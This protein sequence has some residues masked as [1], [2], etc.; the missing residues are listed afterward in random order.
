M[1]TKGA[2]PRYSSPGRRC[3]VGGRLRAWRGCHLGAK[4][5]FPVIGVA[6][7]AYRYRRAARAHL[8]A[9]TGLAVVKIR[10]NSNKLK[11]TYVTGLHGVQQGPPGADAATG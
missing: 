6:D 1:E 9:V 4:L 10:K 2:W 5:A 3:S 11:C 7:S 8:L